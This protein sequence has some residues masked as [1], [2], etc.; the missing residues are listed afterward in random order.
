MNIVIT[1]VIIIPF[2][3]NLPYFFM[4]F[5]WCIIKENENLQL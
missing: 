3:D 2:Y 1:T 5:A 4:Q